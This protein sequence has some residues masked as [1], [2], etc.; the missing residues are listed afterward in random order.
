MILYIFPGKA[1]SGIG[2]EG[3]HPSDGI[4]EKRL[5]D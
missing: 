4:A 1:A 3:L 5:L 2:Q